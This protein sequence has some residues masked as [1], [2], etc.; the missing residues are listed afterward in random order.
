MILYDLPKKHIKLIKALKES[1]KTRE[2]KRCFF[3]EGVRSLEE[4]LKSNFF[5]DFVVAS[6]KFINQD[7]EKSPRLMA[8][9][10]Q[11]KLYSVSEDLF[12]S[13]SDTVTPQGVMAVI[14][15]KFFEPKEYMGGNFLVVALDRIKDPGNMGT[16]IRTADA[17]GVDIIIGG[18]GCVDFYNPKVIRSTM[19]SIFHMPVIETDDL[20]ATLKDLK[21]TG[22][23][24]VTT[25]LA[26]KKYYYELDM[27][28][29]TVIVMGKEDEGVSDE[30]TEI[31]DE[32]VKIPMRGPAESLNVSVAHGIILFEAVKQRM[33]TCP[34]ACK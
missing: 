34:F 32:V 24:I 10:Q 26:A 8:Q 22:G 27:T 13:L 6:T 30:I 2:K 11:F 5:I 18:K 4:A 14:K 1:R 29:P 23:R 33:K 31:S 3:V 19:G 9:L 25:H 20:A 17:A 15:M 21:N 28:G 16:I 7:S 12:D